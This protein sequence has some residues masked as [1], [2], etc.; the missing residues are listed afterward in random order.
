M[1]NKAKQRRHF[2]LVGHAG[3]FNR[4]CE[5]ILDS[6]F[7]L[8]DESFHNPTFTVVSFDWAN[9]RH[10]SEQWNNVR[11]R[12][13]TPERWRSPR[14]YLRAARRLLRLPAGD[15]RSMHSHLRKEFRKADAVLS[16]GGDNYTTDYSAFPGYYL[17]VLKYAREQGS[18]DVIW[19]ATVGPFDDPDVRNKVIEV[20]KDTSLI[21]AR[22]PLTVEY[23]AS[24]RITHNVRAVADP[25]FLLEP[26]P[27]PAAQSYRVGENRKW[28]GLSVSPMIWRY[29]TDEGHR[30]RSE[31]LVR[32]IDWVVEACGMSVAL[33][34]HVVD[35]R[36]TASP[37]NNDH[38]FLSQILER[39]RRKEPLVLADLSLRVREIKYIIS[40]CHFFIGSRTHSTISALS[41]GVPTISLSYSMKSRGINRQVLGNE[42]FVL[43]VNDLSFEKLQD[44]FQ[45]LLAGEEQ[46]RATLQQKIPE[47]KRMARKNAQYLAE[48]LGDEPSEQEDDSGGA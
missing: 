34:P 12:N 14:W 19:G 33:I 13:V 39:T 18:R 7:H 2:L 1:T 31:V 3:V 45:R 28:L 36:P 43:P 6:T 35:T 29:V 32:F 46:I 24:L 26:L 9:D 47:V 41:S 38:R 40:R 27:S 8:L 17:D 37:N 48:L 5:A 23:L 15:W 4:G 22:D 21:T 25:A 44:A 30:D 20:L 11:F 42:D 16:V 10:H